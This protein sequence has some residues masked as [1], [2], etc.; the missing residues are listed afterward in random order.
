MRQQRELQY[1][2]DVLQRLSDH[3]YIEEQVIGAHISGAQLRIDAVLRP[4]MAMLWANESVALGIEF[5]ARDS[6]KNDARS[7]TGWMAQAVDYSL[8]NWAGY[9]HLPIFICPGIDLNDLPPE[10]R[11]REVVRF[12]ERVLSQF[13]IGVLTHSD[14]LGYHFLSQGDHKIWSELYGVQEGKR[15]KLDRKI[16]SR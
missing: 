9:G 15:W 12:A 5:K 16:G 6:I 2:Q 3:F 11:T 4:K 1:S 13:N 10:F 14:H 7:F 8:T